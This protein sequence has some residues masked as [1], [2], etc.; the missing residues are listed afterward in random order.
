[1][2]ETPTIQPREAADALSQ[3]RGEAL[4]LAA[5]E[6]QVPRVEPVKAA[7]RGLA[8]AQQV[9]RDAALFD[10]ELPLV[11]PE[12]RQAMS[13][14]SLALWAAHHAYL[15]SQDEAQK[16][17]GELRDLYEEASRWRRKL[18]AAATF[19]WMEDKQVQRILARIRKGHGYQ[20][21]ADDLLALA[22]LFKERWEEARAATSVTLEQIKDADALA[23]RFL[24]TMGSP[25]EEQP[26]EP[27]PREF[28]NR[29]WTLFMRAYSEML[30]AG[31]YLYR[32][33]PDG[34]ELY[35]S[36][37]ERQT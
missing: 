27:D 11:T 17:S 16:R 4:A 6:V 15:N 25:T 37:F 20:D 32:N 30:A 1:M 22:L 14:L 33:D 19:I 34:E 28:R 2:P 29:I 5:A 23:T 36:L 35:R 21:Q 26:A 8:M 24:S 10:R 7:G 3:V 18:L 13:V 12:S 9:A 31:R